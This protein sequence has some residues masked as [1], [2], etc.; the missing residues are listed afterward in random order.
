MARGT[1]LVMS[2]L[3]GY[4]W[5]RQNASI[6]LPL[7][8]TM[9]ALRARYHWVEM[10]D[11]PGK[12]AAILLCRALPWRSGALFNRGHWPTA[13]SSGQKPQRSCEQSTGMKLA[14]G[15]PWSPPVP[16]VLLRAYLT[17][18]PFGTGR[19]SAHRLSVSHITAPVA[20]PVRSALI[21]GQV[22]PMQADGGPGCKPMHRHLVGRRGLCKD[23]HSMGVEQEPARAP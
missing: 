12:R 10:T 9:W 14:L 8:Y 13:V 20:A 17:V 21:C 18:Q 4:T 15:P 22:I 3:K 23:L 2:M 19:R 16:S 6:D 1:I 7:L 5:G 11:E